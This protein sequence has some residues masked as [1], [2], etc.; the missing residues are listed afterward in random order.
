LPLKGNGCAG[1]YTISGVDVNRTVKT[2]EVD[3]C[4]IKDVTGYNGGSFLLL[5]GRCPIMRFLI[6]FVCYLLCQCSFLQSKENPAQQDRTADADQ[7]D[8]TTVQ[9]PRVPRVTVKGDVMKR[10]LI[11]KVIPNYPYEARQRG[12]AGIVILHVLIG[13]DGSVKQIDYVSGPDMLV[14]AT[15]DGVRQYKYKPT[16]EN[17]QPAEVDTTVE[18]VFSLTH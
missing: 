17:G 13:V 1:F 10:K 6:V 4:G 3:R 16:T 11:R 12:I 15:V 14:K 2:I 7:Q 5:V 18:T 8:K 9:A